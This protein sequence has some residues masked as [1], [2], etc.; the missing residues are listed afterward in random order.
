MIIRRFQKIR[1]VAL[2]VLAATVAVAADADQ[3][4]LDLGGK[5]LPWTAPVTGQWTRPAS[6]APKTP[7]HTS[8]VLQPPLS[9][10]HMRPGKV[11]TTRLSQY[12]HHRPFFIVGSDP[13][14]LRW[15]Q[16]RKPY[17]VK[18]NATGLI[19]SVPSSESLRE[20]HSRLAPL[21]SQLIPGDALAQSLNL[22]RYPALIYRG[23]I[24][25]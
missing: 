2:T 5:P 4:V 21:E 9:A 13:L 7:S 11:Y 6:R 14:S 8:A 15:L 17:L 22:D 20:L 23:E 19:V 3:R 25:Q 18:I 10:T 12:Q 24:Q 1:R 16:T